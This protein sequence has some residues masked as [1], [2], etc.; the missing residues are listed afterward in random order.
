MLGA[1]DDEDFCLLSPIALTTKHSIPHSQPLEYNDTRRVF[2]PYF[3]FAPKAGM[4]PGVQV[5]QRNH[6]GIINAT[7]MGEVR[8]LFGADRYSEISSHPSGT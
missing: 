5:R 3:Q 6:G 4:G 8:P 1:Q 7:V 2:L